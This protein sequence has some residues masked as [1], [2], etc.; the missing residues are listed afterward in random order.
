VDSELFG[1]EKGAFTGAL[2]Q[3]RGRFERA[4]KGTIFLDEISELPSKRGGQSAGHQFQYLEKQDEQAGDWIW[5][6]AKAK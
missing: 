6:K 4:D 3:K 5:T 2:S 1:H